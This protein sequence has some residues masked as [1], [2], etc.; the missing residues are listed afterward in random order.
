[1]GDLI[2]L[3]LIVAMCAGYWKIF[4]KAGIEGWKS[5]V[6]I[7][8]IIT[9]MKMVNRPTLYIILMFVPFANIYAFWVLSQDLAKC[10]GKTS[11]FGVGM[12]FLPFVFV[13]ML[14]FSDA[15]FTAPGAALAAPEAPAA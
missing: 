10:F 6:P 7:L 12:F 15:V 9:M 8:N 11:G 4:T 14:G 5:I 2:E 13:P 1:M 3:A